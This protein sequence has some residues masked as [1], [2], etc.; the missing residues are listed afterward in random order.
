MRFLL[1]TN[2][3][4]EGRRTRPD[5]RVVAWIGRADRA[6]LHISVLTVGELL[7][8]S[9]AIARRDPRAGQGLSQWLAGIKELYAD[10]IVPV[11]GHIAE[12]WG[13]LSADRPRAIIDTLL[14]AT[15]L[16]H[17]MTL[18]TRNVRDV[19]DTGVALLNPWEAA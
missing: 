12:T 8:G 10:R 16:V 2:V 15:A 6:A 11:D 17:R 18:V 7:R 3:L 5:P 13:R 1:D 4:S 14:A 19:H 9:V